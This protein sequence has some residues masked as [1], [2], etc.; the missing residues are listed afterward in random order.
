[1]GGSLK[2]LQSFIADSVR[3]GGAVGSDGD[4]A[5]RAE[6]LLSSKRGLGAESRLEI[7]REQFWLRHHS[8]LNDDFP[9]LAWVIG[10]DA[11]RELVA[12]YLE[13]FPPRT[14]NLQRLGADLP[15]Y[16]TTH[17]RWRDDL[18]AVDASHLDWAFMEA[19]DAPDAGPL[20]LRTF[21]GATEEAWTAARLSL[22]PSLRRVG[23]GH[24]VHEL[25][26][27]VRRRDARERPPASR[28]H[29]VVWRDATWHVRATAIEPMAFDL[30]GQLGE[31]V[32]LGRACETVAAN[33]GIEDA[34][35]LGVRLGEWF[36]QWTANGW[37]CAVHVES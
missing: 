19:F 34:A 13:A 9:T 31:G 36:R 12:G 25:R 7:Y 16:T 11:F 20:D 17:A 10:L 26:E 24:S 33:A 22:H 23:L 27:A 4:L 21:A 28:V 32:P 2:A 30:L 18:L 14:W 35:D 37:V 8:N 1:V 3:R 15:Q 29:V 6:Q 5:I